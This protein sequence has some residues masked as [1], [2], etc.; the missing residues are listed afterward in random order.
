MVIK[1]SVPVSQEFIR[2]YLQRVVEL[3][4]LPDF[5]TKMNVFINRKKIGGVDKIIVV[6]HC[7]KS[8]FE[9][10]RENI[11]RQLGFVRDLPGFN[12]SAHIYGP[13]PTHLALE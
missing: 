8:N 7:D 12:L 6:Y 11:A 13:H 5:I 1:C 9:A 2:D 3:P 10:A 4:P